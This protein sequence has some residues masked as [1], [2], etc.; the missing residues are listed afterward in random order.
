MIV[1]LEAILATTMKRI[2]LIYIYI[3]IYTYQDWIYATRTT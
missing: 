2:I 3:Y 1:Q